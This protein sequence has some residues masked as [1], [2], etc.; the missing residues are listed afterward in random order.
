MCAVVSSGRVSGTAD[1]GAA[2]ASV[3]L[4]RVVSVV[5]FVAAQRRRGAVRVGA[6][7]APLTAQERVPG[8]AASRRPRTP[9]TGSRMKSC[10]DSCV[11]GLNHSTHGFFGLFL[12]WKGGDYNSL[13]IENQPTVQKAKMQDFVQ[14]FDFSCQNRF[15]RTFCVHLRMRGDAAFSTKTDV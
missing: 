9:L 3:L 10:L 15:S 6:A 13:A 2:A 11:A 7:T 5:P 12:A 1:A 8:D 4:L 14:I